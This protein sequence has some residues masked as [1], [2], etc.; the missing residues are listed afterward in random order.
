MITTNW[1]AL[2]WLHPIEIHWINYIQLKSIKLI[3]PNWNPSNWL[4]P[5]EIHRID[6]IQLK[7][8]EID[9]IQLKCIELITSS[10][11]VS[12]LFTSNWNTSNWLHRCLLLKS[13]TV[14]LHF[15]FG[16]F[17]HFK[18]ENTL[19]KCYSTLS[20]LIFNELAQRKCWCQSIWLRIDTI[21]LR[22]L[23]YIAKLQTTGIMV[24]DFIG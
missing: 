11:N 7:Y 18:T 10:W 6:D 24:T 17:N 16:E 4:H 5:I 20:W 1:N 19:K 14:I 21:N 3:T 12:K 2:N 8:I 15:V 13:Q 9:Y 23:P 22:A